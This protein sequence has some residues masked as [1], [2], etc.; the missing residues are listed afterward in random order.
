MFKFFKKLS[1]IV[2]LLMTIF[3]IKV[4][5]SKTYYVSKTGS[6]SNEGSLQSPLLTL[7]KAADLV[8][9]GDTVLVMQ[10]TYAGFI[11]KSKNGGEGNWIVF[12]PFQAD[13]VTL[14]SYLNPPSAF[15][16]VQI[17]SCSYVEIN[18]FSITDS[19]PLYDSTNPDDFRQGL[20]REGVHINDQ[21]GQ[22]SRHIR[23][24]NNHMY[25]LGFHGVGAY[26]T[27][28]EFIE[29]INNDMNHV[30]LA[31]RGYGMYIQGKN[32]TIR[33]NFIQHAAGSGIM[34]Q[35]IEES[36]IENNICANNGSLDYGEGDPVY[37]WG[38]AGDGIFCHGAENVIRN[39]ICYENMNWGIRLKAPN[40]HQVNNTTYGNGT[41]GIFVYDN[42][43]AIVRN[44]LSFQ[45]KGETGYSG[46]YW[47][48]TGNTQ[49]HNSW[50]L[51]ITDARFVDP[52][53]GDFRLQAD[54]PAI[55]AGVSIQ[56][57]NIDRQG[58]TRPQGNAWD[59]GAYEF[60]EG[61]EPPPQM[62]FKPSVT[63]VWF[64]QVDGKQEVSTVNAGHWYDLYCY[65][66]DPQG[67]N[68]ISFADV[69]LNHESNSS[70]TVANR[71]GSFSAET[72][73][74]IS[75]S[76]ATSQIWVR[77]DEETLSWTNISGTPGLYI[78]DVQDQYEQDPVER[79]ARVRIKLLEN[80]KSGAWSINAYVLDK[81]GNKSLL[82]V[83]SIQVTAGNVT[84]PP[85][86]PPSL[87]IVVDG[88]Q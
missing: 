12:K 35:R 56:G 3:A 48:G 7:Q 71:G 21:E 57:F 84:N 68:D 19:N 24:I 41:Q 2:M 65:L 74:A 1:P 29:I 61:A 44:N 11:L 37:N 49:D 75:F 46:D 31:K 81:A 85:P 87:R 59:L 34:A 55:D 40:S 58:T 79:F 76:I 78:D 10:G 80:A 53:N 88:N 72:N 66:D 18:G 50:N 5:Y 13:Q 73:Y 4:G 39:N 23:I 25:R 6:N 86:S 82:F 52:G 47:I 33:G 15:R 32:H 45:N 70:G 22:P 42:H 16:A 28:Q 77:Q 38:R 30:G 14:D 60:N 43:N 83:K 69:W 36:L 62:D 9:S 64:S 27:N 67:W 63:D 51:G 20:N 8:A 17:N 26:P 54:S